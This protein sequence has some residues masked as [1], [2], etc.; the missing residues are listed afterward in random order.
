ME[1]AYEKEFYKLEAVAKVLILRDMLPGHVHVPPGHPQECDWGR[2]VRLLIT[3]KSARAS[4]SS[5]LLRFYVERMAFRHGWVWC[6]IYWAQWL[7]QVCDLSR[8]IILLS[9]PKLQHDDRSGWASC[10]PPLRLPQNKLFLAT[11]S[12]NANHRSRWRRKRRIQDDGVVYQHAPCDP[13]ERPRNQ[14]W[15]SQGPIWWQ[16]DLP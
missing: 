4:D 10:F 2:N 5:P 8:P 14:R 16:G 15:A 6:K 13:V 11:A 9:V 1:G 12:W 3:H 7:L